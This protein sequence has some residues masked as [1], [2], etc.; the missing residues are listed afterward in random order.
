M[1]WKIRTFSA[2][3]LSVQEIEY[4]LTKAARDCRCATSD[5]RNRHQ[6][7]RSTVGPRRRKLSDQLSEK[8]E[9][10]A[11]GLHLIITAMHRPA[12]LGSTL[13]G[14]LLRCERTP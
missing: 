9:R 11:V 10:S 4:S 7:K 3:P 8:T 12:D 2:W 14:I 5:S 6:T 1:G 13:D